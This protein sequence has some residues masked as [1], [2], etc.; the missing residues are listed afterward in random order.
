MLD[1]K[2]GDCFTAKLM[3]VGLVNLAWWENG[4]RHTTNSKRAIVRS[5]TSTA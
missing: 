3:G 5:K 1:G 4:F 2:V